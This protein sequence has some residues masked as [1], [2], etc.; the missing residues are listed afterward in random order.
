HARGI[1]HRDFKPGNVL[2]GAD[3]R[4]RVTDFGLARLAE[5]SDGEIGPAEPLVPLHSTLTVAGA[6]L[7]TPRYMAPEQRAHAPATVH[8]DQYSFCM[9]LWEALCGRLPPERGPGVPRWLLRALAVGL[10]AAPGARHPSMAALLD[11]LE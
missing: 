6:V 1:V 8:S 10:A 2:V 7:G 11:L 5:A 9:A 3:G 4:V